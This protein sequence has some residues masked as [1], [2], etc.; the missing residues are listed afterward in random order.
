MA[1]RISPIA[2]TPA[3]PSSLVDIAKL[4]TAYY[5]E[6]P[7]S[8]I[9]AQ[10]VA[11]GTSGHRGSSF[12]LSFNERHVLAITQAIC[13][14]RKAQGIDGPIFL[15]LDTHALS[16]PASATALEVLAANGVLMAS[17]SEVTLIL[18]AADRL[19]QDG[20][21]VRCVSV[22]SWDLFDAQP[23]AYRDQVLPP[24]VTARLGVELGVEQGW[25]RYVGDRGDILAID[26]FGASAPAQVLLEQYGFTV[27]HVVA[28][29]KDLLLVVRN[30]A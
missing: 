28:R 30:S 1:T 9:P 8:S 25:H 16:R 18:A 23:P 17:G 11:F 3:P 5:T 7:D 6:L 19:D 26:R 24:G 20:I 29:A 14:Y 4:V 2:G 13:R 10:R 15:G 12:D 21:A 27:D 22:P